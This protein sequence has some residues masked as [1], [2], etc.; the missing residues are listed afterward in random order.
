VVQHIGGSWENKKDEEK[1]KKEPR[2]GDPTVYLYGDDSF[3]VRNVYRYDVQSNQIKEKKKTK[4]H[5]P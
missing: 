4:R 1:N 2:G 5:I 3:T